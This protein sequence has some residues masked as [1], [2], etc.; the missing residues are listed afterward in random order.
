M[1]QFEVRLCQAL[2]ALKSGTATKTKDSNFNPFLPY[3]PDVFIRD[4]PDGHVLLFNKF[5][6][7]PNHVLV[8]TKGFASKLRLGKVS[9]L[10]L[11]LE[12]ENQAQKIRQETF[13]AV[14]EVARLYETPENIEWLGFF[15]SGPK[16]GA[17]QC[18]KHL[19]LVPVECMMVPLEA[20]FSENLHASPKQML[21][22]AAFSGFRHAFVR[23]GLGGTELD[24]QYMKESYERLMELMEN[25]SS[26]NLLFTKR[27]MLL[28]PR[29]SSIT[30]DGFGFNAL[31]YA[32]YFMVKSREELESFMRRPSGP[33]RVL[34]ELASPKQ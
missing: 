34:T 7:V 17:S 26:Y 24:S 5:S 6:L 19:Q 2:G 3:D 21:E 14:L 8:I 31:A 33:V 20:A 1:V 27:W 16:A 23:L 13:G 32:G 4:L 9:V 18:H 25:P 10:I 11:L 29:R 12:Y 28:V 30:T 22:I 15:N